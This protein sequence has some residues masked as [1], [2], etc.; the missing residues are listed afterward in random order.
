MLR[1]SAEGEGGGEKDVAA[2][3]HERRKRSI[4]RNTVSPRSITALPPTERRHLRTKFFSRDSNETSR[5]VGGGGGGGGED[6]TMRFPYK[7]A[8]I[9][10]RFRT[11]GVGD[12]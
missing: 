8:A 3:R 1:K 7:G 9:P 5:D 6:V 10:F 12:G 4:V 2:A 11:M